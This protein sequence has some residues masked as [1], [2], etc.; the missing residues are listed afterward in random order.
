MKVV[1]VY[2]DVHPFVRGGIERYVHDLSVHLARSGHR[3]EILVAGTSWSGR[4]GELG[5]GITLTG[6]PCHGRVLSTPV[7]PGL[8]GIL[9]EVDA[10]VFHFHMPLPTAEIAWLQSGRKTPVVATYHS[11][12][13]RQAFL[14]PLYGPFLRAFLR[15]ARTVLPTSPAYVETSRWLRGL[16]N[17]TVVPLGA[18][19]VRFSP[20]GGTPGDYF[21]FVGRFRRYKGIEVLLDAWESFPDRPLVM[22]G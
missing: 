12:I 8:A 21:L 7:S 17:L 20:S 13:V 4:G 3:V 22:V 1:E 9:R 14:L 15:R 2:K 18:D 11:D 19:P 6:Y 5:E 10:D 16:G